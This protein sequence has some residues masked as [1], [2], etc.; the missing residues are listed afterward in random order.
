MGCNEQKGGA[1]HGNRTK[2]HV[3]SFEQERLEKFVAI[4]VGQGRRSQVR[5]RLTTKRRR[6]T[7]LGSRPANPRTVRHT[8]TSK[9]TSRLHCKFPLM[10]QSGHRR[11]SLIDFERL[12][13]SLASL[14]RVT[15][16]GEISSK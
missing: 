3:I 15:C 14:R 11:P 12:T 9:R 4:R 7:K 1:R 2:W 16:V 8:I 6:F 13:S 10:T 5:I